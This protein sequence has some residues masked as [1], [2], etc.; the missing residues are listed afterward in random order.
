M[1]PCY[2][3]VN[4]T[5][6]VGTWTLLGEFPDVRFL[7][8]SNFNP[9]EELILG[10]DVWK[11]FPLWN[12]AYPMDPARPSIPQAEQFSPWSLDGGRK[13]VFTCLPHVASDAVT[14]L[15]ALIAPVAAERDRW[16]AQA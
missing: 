1:L 11:I 16:Q 2:A 9:G 7:N 15:Q 3:G 14:K 5:P 6:Y 8:I 13:V 4:R 10:T 12:K